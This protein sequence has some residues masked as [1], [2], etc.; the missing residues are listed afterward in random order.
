MP[1]HSLPTCP[2][3]AT[4]SIWPKWGPALS[5][6]GDPAELRA[7]ARTLSDNAGT[8]KAIAGRQRHLHDGG[9]TGIAADAFHAHLTRQATRHIGAADA[10]Q[11]AAAALTELAD[12][13]E[14]ARTYA[15][16]A[17]A[18][19]ADGDRDQRSDRSAD[20]A[21][22]EQE[23]RDLLDDTRAQLADVHARVR[24]RP[25]PPSTAAALPPPPAPGPRPRRV[26]SPPPYPP[27]PPA[28]PRPAPGRAADPAP[29]PAPGTVAG[30]V[31][32]TAGDTS[33]DAAE[34][35]RVTRWADPRAGGRRVVVRRGDTLS[36]IAARYLGDGSRWPEIFDD[37]P[38][39]ADPWD[40]RPGQT[41]TLPET[42]PPD[43]GAAHHCC[44][45][46]V[47]HMSGVIPPVSTLGGA[48]A[49]PGWVPGRGL[50][51]MVSAG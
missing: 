7:A 40:I 16:R 29:D 35:S 13:I 24:V 18:L 14:Q 8:H 36:A 20:L 19:H 10:A 2:C 51:V 34:L 48:E 44:P 31:A 42:T 49:P 12:G 47:V 30:T 3:P 33:T 5:I 43:G 17:A 28:R 37:N 22:R 6:P 23:A 15:G 27:R 26:R 45:S 41:L 25:A 39:I 21:L 50:V 11:A 4:G 46:F 32:S 1:C 9:W 38:A